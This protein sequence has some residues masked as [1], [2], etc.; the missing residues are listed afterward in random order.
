MNGYKKDEIVTR[1]SH[2]KKFLLDQGSSVGKARFLITGE[3]G[4]DLTPLYVGYDN[5]PDF[6][7]PAGERTGR[8]YLWAQV[9]ESYGNLQDHVETVELFLPKENDEIPEG[10]YFLN[11]FIQSNYTIMVFANVNAIGLNQ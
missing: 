5:R 2:L 8:M 1:K 7:K 10:F 3:P 11:H 6:R 4:Q 9:H